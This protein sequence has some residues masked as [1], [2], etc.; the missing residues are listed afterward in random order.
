LAI[1]TRN[2]IT[3][4]VL[5]GGRGTRMG[6]ADKGLVDFEGR[7]LAA[8]VLERLA[9]QV[10]ALLV[11][12]NRNLDRYAAL[13]APVVA[14]LPGTEP[15]AGPLAGIRAAFDAIRTPWLAVVPCDTPKIPPDLVARLAAGLNGA[16]AAVAVAGG[17]MQGL[18]CL[19]HVELRESLIESLGRGARRVGDWLSSVGARPVEFDDARAF[20]NL[21]ASV[22][23]QAAVLQSR[24]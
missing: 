1:P 4:L 10:G 12:A 21:N 5:A 17:R 9:P 24:S 19:V 8:H 14:D 13:G 3:G 6:G 15:F 2:E 22:D 23:L 18:C 7:P 20:A 16:K 11:S